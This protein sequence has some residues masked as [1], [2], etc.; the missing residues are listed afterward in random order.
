MCV[1]DLNL[2]IVLFLNVNAN[3]LIW[4][5]EHLFSAF[6]SSVK[7]K[8]PYSELFETFSSSSTIHGTF[9]WFY[10]TNWV[11]KIFWFFVVFCGISAAIYIIDNSFKAW[12]S[13]PVITAVEQIPIERVPFPSITICEL[14]YLII[15][16]LLICFA[17]FWNMQSLKKLF[18]FESLEVLT[19]I[20]PQRVF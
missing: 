11:P 20:W 7:E 5:L 4:L 9:F 8:S 18:I 3:K 14:L 15:L 2:P 17:T 16:L 13:N 6:S 1:W 10:C 19:L 12:E